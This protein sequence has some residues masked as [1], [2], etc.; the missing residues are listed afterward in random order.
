MHIRIK[1]LL[2]REGRVTYWLATCAQKPKI[3][4]SSPAVVPICRGALSPAIARIMSKCLW[5]RWK[6]LWGKFLPLPLHSCDSWMAVEE[7]PDRKEK[8]EI[9][10]ILISLISLFFNKRGFKAL[11]SANH[12][13]AICK[14]RKNAAFWLAEKIILIHFVRKNNRIN[15]MFLLDIYLQKT[16]DNAWR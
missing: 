2:L 6:W 8:E 12:W 1:N 4:G 7:N 3:S 11:F 13:A 14:I 15:L 10:P 5:S 9:K 16:K